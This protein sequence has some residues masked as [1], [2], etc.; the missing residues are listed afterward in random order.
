[1]YAS[2]GNAFNSPATGTDWSDGVV[3][4]GPNA[5]SPPVDYFQPSDW[6]AEN[7]SD[8][9]L[10]SVGPLLVSSG[11]QIFQAGKDGR[12]YLLNPSSLGGVDHETPVAQV[13]AACSGEV[14]GANATID[15]DVYIG[16][17]NGVREVVIN[18]ATNPSTLT[19]GWTAPSG[20]ATKPVAVGGGG[21]WSVG[22]NTLYKLDPNDGHV[23]A[24]HSLSL[25]SAEHFPIAAFG[26]G[27]VIIENNMH[28]VAFPA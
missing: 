8:L 2:T 23:L 1:V 17:T 28:V 26:G 9:D 27:D 3:K 14:L 7:N 16:C 20:T 25:N 19:L 10:G 6:R 11:T 22:G 13:N 24:S 18:R 12:A 4:L 5:T 15:P 21:V